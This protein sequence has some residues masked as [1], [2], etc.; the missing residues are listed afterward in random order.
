MTIRHNRP[1][2]GELLHSSQVLG[3]ANYPSGT[4]APQYRGP[5]DRLGDIFEAEINLQET[6]RRPNPQQPL[7]IENQTNLTIYP[8]SNVVLHMC[9]FSKTNNLIYNL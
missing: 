6:S 8:I 3:G 9:I 2:E 1:S 5:A 4:L 7:N